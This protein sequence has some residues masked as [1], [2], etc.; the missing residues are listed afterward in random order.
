MQ[1]GGIGEQGR[2]CHRIWC[3]SIK[4]SPR[5]MESIPMPRCDGKCC[6]HMAHC[7]GGEQAFFI[8]NAGDPTCLTYVGSEPGQKNSFFSVDVVPDGTSPGATCIMQ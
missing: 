5:L 2:L 4:S 8:K 6:R 7:G 1:A 3:P